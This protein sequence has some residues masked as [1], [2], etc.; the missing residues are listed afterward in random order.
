MAP[1]TLH[2]RHSAVDVQG[3]ARDVSGLAARQI[4]NGGGHVNHTMFWEMMAPG[5]A[6][7][8]AGELAGAIEKA[9]GGLGQFK[10]LASLKDETAANE[11]AIVKDAA[12]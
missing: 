11:R 3:L 1:F 10:D 2:H 5:G 8:P 7:E 6:K 4:N 12:Q 9:F